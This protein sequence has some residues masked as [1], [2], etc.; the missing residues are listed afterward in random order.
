MLPVVN[1][2]VFPSTSQV[3]AQKLPGL[4]NQYYQSHTSL[5]RIVSYQSMVSMRTQPDSP[6]RIA[7]KGAPADARR[8]RKRGEKTRERILNA[9]A[10]AFAAHGL[11]VSM[12]EIAERA[13]VAHTRL[14]YYFEDMHGLW[15]E[16]VKRAGE[17]L[18]AR[19]ALLERSSETLTPVEKL[20]VRLE[21]FVR[22]ALSN[23]EVHRIISHA[24][25]EAG[26][27]M[28]WL[29]SQYIGPEFRR[30]SALIRE[31]QKGGYFVAGDPDHL[32]YLFVGAATRI[33]MQQSEVEEIT[34]LRLN[35]P[36]FVAEHIRLCVSLF[37]REPPS[38]NQS[39]KRRRR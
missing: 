19:Y 36:T 21:E 33:V 1:C 39:P 20:K 7:A 11:D 34:S 17:R 35:R 32:L 18:Y 37:F 3:L 5:G 26:E 4:E 24:A 2:A 22:F 10:K 13:G 6:S 27:P 8:R 16:V 25:Q 29:A 12:R 15:M 31:A 28:H 9:A 14:I 23:P 38:G 30:T